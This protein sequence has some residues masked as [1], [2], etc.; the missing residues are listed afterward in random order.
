MMFHLALVTPER[1]VYEEDVLSVIAPGS[2]GYLGLLSNHAP[3]ITSLR[4]GKLT[5]KARDGKETHFAV[6]GGFLENVATQ[7][8]GLADAAEFAEQIDVERARAALERA[9]Q[10]LRDLAGNIDIP[11][12]RAAQGRAK[13]RLSIVPGKS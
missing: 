1:I 9:R 10:R 7:C 5:V 4:P 8:T 11:R 3:I 2:Q 12:A 13:N 6:S